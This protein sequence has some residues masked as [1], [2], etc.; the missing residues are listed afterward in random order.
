ML[1]LLIIFP[2][3]SYTN[4]NYPIKS[5]ASQVKYPMLHEIPNPSSPPSHADP[6]CQCSKAIAIFVRNGEKQAPLDQYYYNE[7]CFLI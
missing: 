6:N 7:L 3:T 2:K 4:P 5:V 1:K